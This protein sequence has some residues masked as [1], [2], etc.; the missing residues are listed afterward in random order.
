MLK[1][2]V[3]NNVKE[4]FDSIRM[5]WLI[6]TPEEIVRQ[7]F[8]ELI[9]SYGYSKSHICVE[10]GFTLPSKKMQRADIIVRNID[11]SAKILIECKSEDV[12][13]TKDVFEQVSKYNYV[14]KAKYI[15]IT[16][17]K[18]NFIFETK[19]FKDYL[20]IAYFPKV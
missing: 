16:N 4:I 3:T 17:L 7:R 14:I 2:R 6:E 10:Y 12:K 11:G 18:Q 19:N 5:M 9:V 20:P 15:I 8:I 13:L 1:Q